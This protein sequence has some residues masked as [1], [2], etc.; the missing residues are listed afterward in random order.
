MI[1]VRREDQIDANDDVSLQ[2]FVN[3]LGE[4]VG[5]RVLAGFMAVSSLG[6]IIV[7][8]FTMARVKQEIAKE[9]I[10]PFPKFFA[11]NSNLVGCLAKREG[12]LSSLNEP[13]PNGALLLHWVTSVLLI[14]ATWSHDSATDSYSII[15]SL[16]SYTVDA[17]FFFVVAVGLLCL[18]LYTPSSQTPWRQKSPFPHVP[19]IISAAILALA[20][21]F[22]LVVAWIPPSISSSD[23]AVDKEVVEALVP[24]YPWYSTPVIGWSLLG[25]AVVYWL[26]F[27]YV[28]PQIGNRKGK[29]FVVERQPFLRMEH[30]YYIQWHELVD[31]HWHLK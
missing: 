28:L 12:R 7:T 23:S 30:G 29:E 16:Y 10:I 20:T 15:V 5:A 26:C 6:N 3:T 2:F 9:G 1:V 4:D 24:S 22:P 8:C 14:F 17:F 21:A 25:F 31:F 19:S 18:R 27:R 11:E 13:T